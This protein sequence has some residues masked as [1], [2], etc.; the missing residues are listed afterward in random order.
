MANWFYND[1]DGQQA[2]SWQI[3]LFGVVFLLVAAI[4]VLNIGCTKTSGI[5]PP[6][7]ELAAEQ[8]PAP[9]V[10]LP[11]EP[12]G[13]ED[14]LKRVENSVA[15]IEG[16]SGGGT[17]FLIH[18]NVLVTNEHVIREEFIELLKITFPSAPE[19]ERGPHQAKLLYISPEWDIAFLEV[20]VPLP[21][22]PI[23]VDHQFRRG[24]E[25][26]AIGHPGNLKNAVSLGVLSSQY[27]YRGK[28]HYQV[29]MSINSGNSG[30][31]VINRQGE[32][33]GIATASHVKMEAVGFCIPSNDVLE[34]LVEMEQRTEHAKE[35]EDSFHRAMVV[36]RMLNEH[37]ELCQEIIVMT[38]LVGRRALDKGQ[39]PAEE[40]NAFSEDLTKLRHLVELSKSRVDEKVW[41]Q[42]EQD[43]NLSAS[44]RKTLTDFFSLCMESESYALDLKGI[45]ITSFEKKLDEFR[46]RGTRLKSELR[47]ELGMLHFDEED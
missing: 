10:P 33:I 44:L 30:G 3:T 41:K 26:I 47:L 20:Q 36:A 6:A 8:V 21:P 22:L 25:I 2:T 45:P 32:V 24:Q 19:A 34:L 9:P 1:N 11:P 17:G 43:T 27:E 37:H 14:I 38:I 39:S 16:Q 15:H 28:M 35:M 23:A 13:I 7:N 12:E 18:P 5:N 4:A 31:P 46:G 42:V 29:S 40:L